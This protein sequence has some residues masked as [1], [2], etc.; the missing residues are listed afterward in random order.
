MPPGWPHPRF[1]AYVLLARPSLHEPLVAV[2]VE[3]ES[4][5]MAAKICKAFYKACLEAGCEG[6]GIDLK[7][8]LNL[9]GEVRPKLALK[10]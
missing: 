7:D 5:G 1:C 4:E 2:A 3:G 9:G 10:K 8:A 6:A